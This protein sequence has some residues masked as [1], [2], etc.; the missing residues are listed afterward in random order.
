MIGGVRRLERRRVV[1]HT[2]DDRSIRGVLTKNYRDCLVLA[3]AE[4]LH[5]AKPT[6][7]EGDAVI[8]RD[9]VSWLQVL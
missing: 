4:Y 5:E 8:L 7:L 1:I 6:E 3:Q 2:K 9:N